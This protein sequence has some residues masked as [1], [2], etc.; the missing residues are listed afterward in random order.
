[1]INSG[2]KTETAALV[3]NVKA[4]NSV[5]NKAGVYVHFPYCKRK[6][7]YCSFVSTPD[8]S[9]QNAYI[10][11]LKTEIAQR[12]DNLAV[13]TIYFGG[14]TPSITP[15]GGFTEIAAGLRKSFDLS[16]LTEFTAE[17]NPES[18]TPEFLTESREVGVTRLSMGLQSASDE[19]L[20]TI[21][22]LHTVSDFMNAVSL[23]KKFGIENVSGDLIVGLP[24]Q[25]ETDVIKAVELFDKLGLTHVSAYALTVEEGTPLYR[26]G[27]KTDDD[28]EA[29]LYD[30]A[31]GNLR[32]YG[33][34]R[35]EVS[36]FARDGKIAWHNVKYW[37]GADYYGFGAAAHSLVKGRR[38]A[39]TSDIAAYIAD[40]AKPAIQS[41]TDE[42]KRT[43]LVMLRLRTVAGL[44]LAEYKRLTKC[45]LAEEK[46]KEIERLVKYGA[47][48]VDNGK[49]TLTD[50][51][52]YVMNSVIEELL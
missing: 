22:R 23:A 52:F 5:G 14:G 12:S 15:R 25:D 24:G 9:S 50:K 17:A 32:K 39:N 51:G 34:Y 42:D 18:V 7:A 19:I 36:N 13:D 4:I 33:Y 38:I 43:E 16:D 41:L 3:E 28:R 31:V 20:K 46:S 10:Y 11:R 40:T 45:D 1:M 2:E 29:D 30:A 26:S 8:L 47:I 27:Y 49:I 6:C 48:T 44:D 21:G 35:Y 37:T